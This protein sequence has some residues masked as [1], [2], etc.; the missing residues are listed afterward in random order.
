MSGRLCDPGPVH[1]GPEKKKRQGKRLSLVRS[2]VLKNKKTVRPILV[3]PNSAPTSIAVDISNS[4]HGDEKTHKIFLYLLKKSED[5][6]LF[7]NQ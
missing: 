6:K 4:V 5:M 2:L 3:F 7:T 1:F